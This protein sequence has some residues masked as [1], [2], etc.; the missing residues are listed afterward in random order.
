LRSLKKINKDRASYEA[1]KN[2]MDEEKVVQEESANL[3]TNADIIEMTKNKISKSIIIQKIKN[4]KCKFDTSP[5][6]LN[7]LTKS[8]VNEDVI[9]QMMEV[10]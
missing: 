3:L 9:M 4:S 2:Q 7:N 10:K 6:A 5:G 8:G 1:D